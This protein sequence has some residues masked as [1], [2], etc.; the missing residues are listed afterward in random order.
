MNHFQLIAVPSG[1]VNY[2][3]EA[4]LK[5]YKFVV[6]KIRIKSH[7]FG[8]LKN[9]LYSPIPKCTLVIEIS[10]CALGHE[11]LFGKPRAHS[12]SWHKDLG[13]DFL[14][15]LGEHAPPL[16]SKPQRCSSAVSGDVVWFLD[17]VQMFLQVFILSKSP[18]VIEAQTSQSCTRA[19]K[20]GF[21]DL[22]MR[23]LDVYY[24]TEVSTELFHISNWLYCS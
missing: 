21:K 15:E 1:T 8:W 3:K 4:Y 7:N 18:S 24:R 13:M 6:M 23:S 20:C 9:I 16:E 11:L 2:I 14:E 19:S 12:W 10:Q 5:F 17:L 22:W